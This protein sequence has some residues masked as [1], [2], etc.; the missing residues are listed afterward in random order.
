MFGVANNQN[1]GWHALNFKATGFRIIKN[2]PLSQY[3]LT[4]LFLGVKST[5]Y[6]IRLICGWLRSFTSLRLNILF[7]FFISF[8]F[9]LFYFQ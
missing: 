8:I 2:Q 9:S 4:L 7:F 6:E 3:Y 1:Q 5:D